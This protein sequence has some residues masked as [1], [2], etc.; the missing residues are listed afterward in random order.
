MSERLV[1]I[2]FG[3]VASSLVEGL[4]PAVRSKELELTVLGAEK[5]AA[6]NRVLLAEVAIGAAEPGHL[7]MADEPRLRA[8]GVDLRL[9]TAATGVD[10]ARRVVHTSGGP[11]PYDRLVFAT[12]ARPVIP[13]LAGLNFDPHADTELP[14]GVLALRTLNDALALQAV[15]RGDGRVLV[16]GGGIL[17]LEAALAMASAGYRPVLVHHGPAP[18]GRVVDADGGTLLIRQLEA[19]GV[20]VLSGVR[21]TGVQKQDGRFHALATETHG[22]IHA[23]ALLVS[24]G[25]RPRTEL[26]QGCGLAVGHGIQ[27]TAQ[28]AADSSGRLFAVGD[29]AQVAGQRPAGLL[30]PGWAQA[31]W[32]A[33]YLL[34]NPAPHPAASAPDASALPGPQIQASGILMLKGQGL[35]LTAAGTVQAGLFEDPAQQVTVYADPAAGRY[36]KI[37]AR[38]RVPTGFL[39]L[40]LP[41]TGAELALGFERGTPLPVDPSLLLRL[42]APFED[43]Q[44]PAAGADDQLCRCSGATYGQ[45]ARAVDAGCSTVEEVGENCRAGTGCGGC[46]ERIEE[47]LRI[48][49]RV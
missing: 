17:G 25:V 34:A 31:A 3:P 18:L 39:A 37:V 5:R 20:H 19:A 35:E 10:R 38:D 41:R 47:L 48:P 9:G 2:G 11:V 1:V 22:L 44:A 33:D 40:G 29:C 6:Y 45:V 32:L 23:D 42:D 4:L 30:A 14:A 49:A 26:A 16:L 15:L 28:L 13:S 27:V 43:A 21:A 8:A 36:L 12:G 7:G 46:K 24:T